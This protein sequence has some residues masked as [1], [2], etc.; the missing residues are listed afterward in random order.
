MIEGVRI[1]EPQFTFR[2]ERGRIVNPY[3]SG[4]PKVNISVSKK[5]V[6]RGIHVSDGIDKLA[7]CV[8][9]EIY[10]VVVD[11]RIRSGSFCQWQA[12]T[13][14]GEEPLMV[15]VPR[16]CGLAH[17]VLSDEAVFYYA[18]S[19]KFDGLAQRSFRFDDPKFGITWPGNPKLFILSERDRE[20]KMQT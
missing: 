9:G 1:L 15:Y 7:M 16:G 3:E 13:L 6:L 5:N 20:G 10:L 19:D 17:L 18:W 2:D 12:W 14:R 8:S 4:W 11:C